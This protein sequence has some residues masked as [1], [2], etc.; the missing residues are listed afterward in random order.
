[1]LPPAMKRLAQ[2]MSQ[3]FSTRHQGVDDAGVIVV[4]GR[5]EDR[6]WRLAGGETRQ[7]G[8]TGAAATVA[9]EI[10]RQIAECLAFIANRRQ[11]VVVL[12]VVA[13][14]RALWG[15]HCARD[16]LQRS[17][18]IGAF[19]VHRDDDVEARRRH[20]MRLAP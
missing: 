9:H 14:Q 16:R 3:P 12:A 15:R 18:D 19:V 7:Y 1:M 13:D 2:T 17:Q 4:V 11:R 10:D 6:E 20:R 5:Q 8:A